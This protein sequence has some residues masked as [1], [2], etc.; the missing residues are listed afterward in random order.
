[1][2]HLK[3]LYISTTLYL[4]KIG[5]FPTISFGEMNL[6]LGDIILYLGEL[7][8]PPKKTGMI[9]GTCPSIAL[10]LGEVKLSIIFSLEDKNLAFGEVI[11][12]SGRNLLL[13]RGTTLF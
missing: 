4:E 12:F 6:S 11:L 3:G 1:M 13:L 7:G 10:S 9:G 5:L 8:P 2:I